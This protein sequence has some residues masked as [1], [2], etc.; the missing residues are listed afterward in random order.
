MQ[1]SPRVIPSTDHGSLS[2]F[3]FAGSQEDETDQQGQD[4]SQ[5][6]DDNGTFGC[7]LSEFIE[8]IRRSRF[9]NCFLIFLRNFCRSVNMMLHFVLYMSF[10]E[11]R[12][13]S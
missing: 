1:S 9:P 10:I 8:Y 12:H 4:S 7:R 13:K 5:N 2:S 3:C 6:D 11:P